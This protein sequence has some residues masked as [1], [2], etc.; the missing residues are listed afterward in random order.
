M[1]TMTNYL[2]NSSYLLILTIACEVKLPSGGRTERQIQRN[3]FVNPR[4]N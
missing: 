4:L 2:T 3:S 1:P